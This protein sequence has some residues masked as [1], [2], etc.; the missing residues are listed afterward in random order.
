MH[1][2]IL[3]RDR[4]FSFTDP[5]LAQEHF[6]TNSESYGLVITDLKMPGMNGYEFIKNE[7]KSQVKVFFMTAFSIND[8]EFRRILPFVKID[9]FIKKWFH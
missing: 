3:I 7:I 6:Q 8:K 4:V 9:E 5:Y 1:L 2:L